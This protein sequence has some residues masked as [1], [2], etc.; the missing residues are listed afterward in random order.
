MAAAK[1]GNMYK[2]LL[3][4]STSI[5]RL[6]WLL[7]EVGGYTNNRNRSN[8]QECHTAFSASFSV[9]FACE[10]LAEKVTNGNHMITGH[11]NHCKCNLVANHLDHNHVNCRCAGMGKY[12][13]SS[14]K[15]CSFGVVITLNCCCW[16][17]TEDYL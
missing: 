3:R 1:S 12:L 8:L 15:Y 14:Y 4:P 11:C 5:A 17:V 9:N 16:S 7:L 13:R 10:R 2:R 6:G